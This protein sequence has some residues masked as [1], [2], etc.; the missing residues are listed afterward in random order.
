MKPSNVITVLSKLMFEKKNVLLVGSPG[1]GKT[2]IATHVASAIGYDIIIAHPV[3]DSPIDYKGM[4]FKTS[5]DEADFLPYGMLK[6]LIHA[7][8]PTI[9]FLDDIGQAPD[10]VQAALMQLLLSRSINGKKISDHVVFLAATNEKADKAGVSGILEPVKSRFSTI[11]R[12]EVDS[13]DWITWAK[14][15]NMPNELIA[16]VKMSPDTLLGFEATSEI[17][18]TPCPRTVANLGYLH[19]LNFDEDVRVE[20][21]TGAVGNKL[22]CDFVNFCNV[23]KKAPLFGDIIGDPMGCTLPDE[24]DITMRAI[25]CTML[26]DRVTAI[27]FDQII[28][29]LSRM[30]REYAQLVIATVVRKNPDLKSTSSYTTWIMSNQDLY[31]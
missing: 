13:E 16:F 27:N 15:N 18:N 23:I 20:I 22:A 26:I 17:R 30:S 19:N 1:V 5:N 8:T 11:I 12:V 2:D 28:K 24:T 21:Y 31:K 3:V 10:S 7:T 9:F 6:K 29:Y 14:N 25:V 4:P